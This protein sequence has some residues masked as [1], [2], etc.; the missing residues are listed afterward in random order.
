MTKPYHNCQELGPG[1]RGA[2]PE[3]YTVLGTEVGHQSLARPARLRPGNSGRVHNE[4]HMIIA[5]LIVDDSETWQQKPGYDIEY[6][7]AARSRRPGGAQHG[8]WP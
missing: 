7:Q 3:L 6:M 8:L 4:W 1:Q 5:H 2:G